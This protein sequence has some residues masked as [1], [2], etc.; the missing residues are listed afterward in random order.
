VSDAEIEEGSR[1]CLVAAP[2]FCGT[3]KRIT[4]GIA[5]VCFDNWEGYGNRPLEELAVS[6]VPE[7]KVVFRVMAPAPLQ[8]IAAWK[9]Y[10]FALQNN[11]HLRI[12]Q[13]WDDADL[14]ADEL[15]PAVLALLGYINRRSDYSEREHECVAQALN[16]VAVKLEA[17]SE[18]VSPWS[19]S[20]IDDAAR[21]GKTPD[22]LWAE[23]REWQ[24]AKGANS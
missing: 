15:L 3:V 4:D 24:R 1:V 9:R 14:P 5:T 11:G 23:F 18:V 13:D 21:L 22:A 6:E 7:P 19:Q 20:F 10:V 17:V 2:T 8:N 16:A 12:S